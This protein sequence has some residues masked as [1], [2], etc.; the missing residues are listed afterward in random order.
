VLQHGHRVVLHDAQVVQLL[1]RDVL[2]QGAD[3]GRMHFDA[4]KV[5]LRRR[6]G[7]RRGGAA[8][9]E[10]DFKD[11]RRGAPERNCGV[12]RLLAERQHITRRQFAQCALLAR[13]HAAGA[14]HV[15]AHA[16]FLIRHVSGAR[17]PE[18]ADAPPWGAAS[19]ASVGA[20][21]WR[22]ILGRRVATPV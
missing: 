19:E 13:A 18:G 21:S 6:R 1:S 7:D 2:Q 12:E 9:A 4:E 16:S 11:E 17:P 10:A 15:A 8:H 20:N 14:Q 5:E 3:A 22:R